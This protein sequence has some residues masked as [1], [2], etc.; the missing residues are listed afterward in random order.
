[1]KFS[2]LF[3]LLVLFSNYCLSQNDSIKSSEQILK[4]L[5]LNSSEEWEHKKNAMDAEIEQLMN[6][7]KDKLKMSSSQKEAV[8][9][10]PTNNEIYYDELNIKLKLLYQKYSEQLNYDAM[11]LTFYDIP[12]QSTDVNSLSFQDRLYIKD[13][14][15]EAYKDNLSNL[16]GKLIM[17][18]NNK[19][20][21]L[22]ED[23]KKDTIA[24]SQFV[25][26][27]GEIET[28]KYKKGDDVNLGLFISAN[29]KSEEII[30]YSISDVS[31]MVIKEKELDKV[32]LKQKLETLEKYYEGKKFKIVLGV[33]VTEITSKKFIKNSK[34]IKANSFPALGSAFSFDSHFY[35]STENYKRIYRIG[36][37][38][39]E[40][41][42]V[43]L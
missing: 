23:F 7:Y 38:A 31:R 11:E 9:E 43:M 27:D 24:S 21:L 6:E 16:V 41:S 37:T 42:S 25:P 30:E 13:M 40:I 36:F 10:N 1:M 26:K 22:F 14:G 34:T 12:K 4:V 35:I 19:S 3:F 28:F 18:D 15:L 33:T 29:L 17:V 8:I 32:K 5:G 39:F 2:I 20:T